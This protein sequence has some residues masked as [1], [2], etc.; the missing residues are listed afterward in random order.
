MRV[1]IEDYKGWGIYFDTEKEDF[2]TISNQYD[3]E[4][5]KRSYSSTKKFID[6]YIKENNEFKPIKVQKMPSMYSDGEIITLIGIR[7]DKSFMYQDKDGNKK[8]L[9]RYNESDYFLVDAKNEKYFNRIEELSIER[10]KLD[11]ELKEIEKSI[12]KLDVKQ[13]RKNLFGE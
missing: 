12:I 11:N 13:I 9:S 10:S 3:K 6:D 7:K 1:L 8:Q 5:T 4:Q 2:Y